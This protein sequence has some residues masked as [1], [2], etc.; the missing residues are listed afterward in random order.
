MG[1]F[2]ATFSNKATFTKGAGNQRR[3][4]TGGEEGNIVNLSRNVGYQETQPKGIDLNR[5]LVGGKLK[6]VAVN[7][8]R[9]RAGKPKAQEEYIE[10]SRDKSRKTAVTT[11]WHWPQKQR[12]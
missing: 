5:N 12:K 11:W 9:T 3:E 4:V 1:D 2:K 7:N 6:K 8:S 10:L